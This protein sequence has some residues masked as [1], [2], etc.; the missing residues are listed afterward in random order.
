M[1]LFLM[2][3]TRTACCNLWLDSLVSSGP[4][5]TLPTQRECE[6]KTTF[7]PTYVLVNIQASDVFVVFL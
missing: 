3:K 7:Y 6:F 4:E 5:L 1:W 2:V